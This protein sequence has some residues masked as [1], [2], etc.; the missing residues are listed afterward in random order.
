[1]K[2]AVIGGGAAGFFAAITCKEH[3]PNSKVSIIEKSSKVLSKVKVSGGGRCN[4]TNACFE[5]K[6]LSEHYPRGQNQLRKAFEQFNAYDTIKWFESK[7]VK[8]KIYD[9]NC[10]FPLSNDSQSIIDCFLNEVKRL[11]IELKL[12]QQ[13]KQID[14]I[15][16]KFLVQTDE[17][18]ME[19]DRVIIAIGGQPKITG[20]RFLSEIEHNII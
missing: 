13:I 16:D 19:F 2:V 8:V 15:E 9:D 5:N 7:G 11:G 14:H 12:S 6:K 17:L 18:K 3:F 20:F 1:M 4:L 10:V